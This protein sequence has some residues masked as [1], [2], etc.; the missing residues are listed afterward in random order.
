[1]VPTEGDVCHLLATLLPLCVL[2]HLTWAAG[3]GVSS[4]RRM[5]EEGRTCF[6][7]ILTT[8]RMGW[9]QMLQRIFCWC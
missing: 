3:M 6:C 2:L 7:P 1:M 8:F 4:P 5:L 9:Q